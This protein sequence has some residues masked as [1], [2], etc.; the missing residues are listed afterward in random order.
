TRRGDP[1]VW[2]YVIAHCLLH[3]GFGHLQTGDR[4]AREWNIAADCA[5]ARFLANLKLGERPVDIR[6]PATF[7]SQSEEDLYRRLCEE[8]IPV[9]LTELGTAGPRTTDFVGHPGGVPSSWRSRT[10]WSRLLGQG[11]SRA[12]SRSLSVAAGVHN[13]L[14]AEA[15]TNSAAM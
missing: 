8:G 2:V 11:L 14:G 6:L 3:L 10:D 5:V 15:A 1:E 4:R 12:V 9:E 13:H 7:P